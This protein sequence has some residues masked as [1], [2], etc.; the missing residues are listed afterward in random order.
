MHFKFIHSL[1]T[2]AFVSQFHFDCSIVLLLLLLLHSLPS[3]HPFIHSFS[4][5]SLSS[6]MLI[7]Q[8]RAACNKEHRQQN[9]Y[10]FDVIMYC[11]VNTE[12]FQR[13]YTI[14]YSFLC[15]YILPNAIMD[16]NVSIITDCVVIV[17]SVQYT[18][19]H[20]SFD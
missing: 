5:S 13:F 3:I 12:I 2:F 10:S 19:D 11:T 14:V 1:H 7:F 15:A 4:F 9:I 17:H 16:Q 18:S 6:K 8:M 20:A